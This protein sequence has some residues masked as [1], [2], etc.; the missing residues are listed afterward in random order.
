MKTSGTLS[1]RA[2]LKSTA[3]SLAAA[4]LVTGVGTKLAAEASGTATDCDGELLGQGELRYRARR[5]W[6]LLDRGHYP[7]KDCHGITEDRNGRIVLLTNDTQNNLIAYDK[8]G[9]FAAAWE[10][11]FPAAHGLEIEDH[12]GEDRYWITDHDVQC[13]SI[14]SADGHELR[15]IGAG[16]VASKYPDISKYHPTNAAFTA[17]GDFFIS[18]GYGSS[19]V[20][21]FDPH[22]RYISSFGGTGNTPEHLNEP[23][24]VWIDTRF[25]KPSVLVCDRGNET[26]KW[27]SLSGELQ[28]SVPVPGAR[29]SNV[30]QFHNADGRFK[31]HIAVASLNGMILVLDGSDRVVSAVGGEP[32][33]Y[34]DGKLEPLQVFNYTF[35]HPHDVYVD[36]AGALYVPQ[37]WSNQTY[38][39]KLELA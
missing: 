23:H 19:F 21:H 37:W 25:G 13:L 34:K 15:R 11:H 10:T 38:P 32:P 39:I 26:L 7:V 29:P 17:D 4:G 12:Q 8:S 36:T 28:R 2:L 31:N 14:N 3:H 27:F 20:H 18:D 5:H 1:R 33:V 9:K 6:G 30:A 24:A 16:A 35:N 22:A